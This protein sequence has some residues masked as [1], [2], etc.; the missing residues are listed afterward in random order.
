STTISVLINGDTIV[1]NNETFSLKLE[2]ITNAIFTPESISAIGTIINDDEE[3]MEPFTCNESLYLSNRTELGTGS[4][5]SGKTWLHRFYAMTPTYDPIGD[6]FTSDNGGYNAMGYNVQDNYIYAMYGNELLKIDKNSNIKNLG[7]IAGLPNTQLYAGEFDRDGFY[8]VSGNGGDDNK[9]YKI[10]IAQKKVIKTITLSQ[11]VRFWDMAIDTTGEYFY[12]MLIQDGDDNS[13]FKNSKFAK[14]KISDGTIT[15][16]GKS[17]DDLSSYISLIFSD[18]KGKVI[19]VAQ[20]GKMYE[21]MPQ[22]GKVYFTRPFAPLSFYNDGTSCPDANITLPPH[23][24]RLS[25]NNVSQ[26]EGDSGETTF[27]FTVTAD[28]PFDMSFISGAMFLYK[29]VDGDG[30]EVVPP[31]EVALSR[32]HD[33]KAVSIGIGM[34]INMFGD[35]VSINLP[36]TVY[37]DKKIEADEEFYVEIYSPQ[38][39]IGMSPKYIIDKNIGIGTIL[40]DD[41]DVDDDNDGIFNNIEYGSCSTGIEKLMS[42]DNFG[43]GDRTNSPYTTY[44]YEDGDGSVECQKN[45]NIPYWEGNVNVNDGEYAVV[46]HPNPDASV[47]SNWTTQGDH[48]G[49]PNGRMMVVNASLEPDEFFRKTYTI[50]PHANMTVDL[51]ILNV[52]KHGSNI[53]LPNI[54]FKSEDMN[55]NQVGDI[56]ATGDIPENGQWNHYTLS[57]NPQENRQIQVVLSNNAPG[58]GGN[59]LALDDIRVTQ[60]FCDHD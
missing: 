26:L 38:I 11:S 55:G 15:P 51:W 14:I 27:N 4:E 56:V 48:T 23:P 41:N 36:V 43:A 25:I 13:D 37:G 29:V 20:D 6:G 24:P 59:D 47:F 19:A 31:H 18:A 45:K 12:T 44:C 46:Q 5:D 40:N 52:V 50:V 34:G 53:I 57:I 7:A 42:F 49:N 39:P 21:I 54:S 35:G 30:N 9:M 32:D 22:S 33:F 28:K 2:N 1:E 16:I 8:Y 10:D 60:T 3:E 58:G 17:H